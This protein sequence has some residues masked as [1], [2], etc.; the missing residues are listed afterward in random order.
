MTTS[1]PTAS[2]DEPATSPKPHVLIIGAGITGLV[3]AQALKKHE[4]AHTV[5]ERDVDVSARGKGWGLTIHWSL[6]TFISLLP[7]HIVDKLPQVYVDPEASK[8]GDNGNFLFFDLRSG[9]TRWKVPPNKRIRV[10]RERLRALLLEGLDVQWSKTL[11]S[12][13]YPGLDTVIAHFSDHTSAAGMLLIGAD[14]SRSR[15]RSLLLAHEPHLA[16]NNVLPV[17]LLG[18]SVVYP[19][20]LALRMRALDPFFFQGGDP[21]SDAFMWFSFLDTPANNSREDPDTYECQILISWPHRNGFRGVNKPLDIP[22]TNEEQ[23]RLMKELVDGWANPFHDCVMNI[24]ADAEI[25]AIALEDFV[26]RPG[27][28]DNRS[29]RV[30]LMGDAAHAMTMCRFLPCFP[31][32]R[33]PKAY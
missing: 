3:L 24:P 17:R 26:P 25:K 1:P 4:I 16:I 13:S 29:G 33:H 32:Y 8:R 27:L 15:A 31:A 21:A 20:D 19:Q 11:E 12:I 14:G 18:A 9:T 10:S 6:D 28:W 7:Q 30:T 23:I 2:H 22:A 5:F